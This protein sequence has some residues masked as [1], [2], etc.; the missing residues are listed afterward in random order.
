MKTYVIRNGK[1]KP[2]K[3]LGWLLRNWK[4]VES[5]EIDLPHG[6]TLAEA[7]LVA[8]L[9]DGDSYVCEFASYNILRNWLHR[10]VFMGM[11]VDDKI[12]NIKF[13]IS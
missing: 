5:F 10:P 3:N 1:Q 2:V 4:Q 6:Q 8:L 7:T 13:K 9:R 11:E 12:S